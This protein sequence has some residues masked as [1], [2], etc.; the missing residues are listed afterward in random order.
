MQETNEELG[1]LLK[2]LKA[3]SSDLEPVQAA[4]VRDAHRCHMH[5]AAIVHPQT[6]FDQPDPA[7]VHSQATVAQPAHCSCA[8][9]NPKHKTY[10]HDH[11]HLLQAICPQYSNH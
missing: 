1:R 5:A 6:A 3:H 10:K 11:S 7:C 4:V 8:Q 9:P 2:S